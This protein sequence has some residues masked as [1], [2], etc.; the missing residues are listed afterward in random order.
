MI[1]DIEAQAQAFYERVKDLSREARSTLFKQLPEAVSKA[2]CKILHNSYFAPENAVLERRREHLSESG[3]YKL[4]VTPFT[5]GESSWDYTQGLVYGQGSDKPIAEVRRNYSSFPFL[6]IEAH[7]NGHSYLVCGEDYQGQTVIELDTGARRDF[8]PEE[9][10]KGFGFCW[11]YCEFD[12]GSQILTVEGCYW[13]C[14]YEYKFYDFSDP[15]VLGWPELTSETTVDR[16]PR[17]PSFEADGTIKTYKTVP[18]STNDVEEDDDYDDEE[19][20]PL[21]RVVASTHSFRREGSSLTLVGEWVS[22]EEQRRRAEREKGEREFKEYWANFEASDPLYRA[23][24]ELLKDPSLS[25]EEYDWRGRTYAGWCPAM[26]LDE[27]RLG[28]R[29]VKRAG[30]TI[31]FEWAIKTGPVKLDIFRNGALSETK[32]FMD[33]SVESIK[34]AFD[35]AKEVARVG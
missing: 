18:A 33:H 10:K 2:Y 28:R 35:Y 7:P 22:E 16:D 14:P 30:L 24:I 29:V 21:E 5:T 20:N 26:A 6:F 34:A 1:H 13:A 15:M 8:L 12:E 17:K 25:P 31:D 32:F 11:A 19:G 4:V 3:K 27:I 23:Y 9:A